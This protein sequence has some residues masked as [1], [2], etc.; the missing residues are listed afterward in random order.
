M[1]GRSLILLAVLLLPLAPAAAETVSVGGSPEG[2]SVELV[3]SGALRTVL[4]Y[5]IGSFER[6]TVEID[7][8][9]YD[10]VS[11][12]GESDIMTSGLPL[13]PDVARSIIIPD[14]AEM[15][16]RV[17]SADYID[18]AGVRVAP[19]KGILTRDI[20]PATVPYSFDGFYETD[21]WYPSELAYAREPYIMRDV[22]GQVVVVNPFQY[23]PSLETLRIYDR[24]EI[25]VVSV[26]PGKTNVLERRPPGGVDHEFRKIY[27]SHFLNFPSGEDRLRYTPIGEVGNMLV[28]CYDSFMASM[29]PFVEWK[30]QMGV[31]CEMVA[32]STVGSNATAIR[33]YIQDYYDTSGVTFVLL[34]GDATEIP[35]LSS[36][37]GA[38]DPSY[39]LVAGD[40]NYPD[41][42][43]G[44]FSATNTLDVDTQVL[45][46]VEYE[47]LPQSEESWYRKATG[48][49]SNQGPGDDG[50]DDDEHLE[51]IR[52]YL[53]EYTYTVVDQIYDPDANPAMVTTA[54]NDGRGLVNYTGHGSMTSWSSSDF[55]S[56]H[57]NALVNDNMLPFIISVACVNGRFDVGTCFAEA[58][59]RAT[60]DG[61]PTGALATYMSSIN[62]SWN[63]PMCAQDEVVRLLVNE[64]KR[65]FGGLCMNG[66]CQ[67]I[68]E[69]GAD[70]VSMFKTWH[71]FGDPS[72]RVRTNTPTSLT[73]THDASLD[74]LAG[75]FDVSVPGLEGAL[76]A[77]YYDGVLYGSAFTDSSGVAVIDIA[78]TPPSGIDVTVTVTAFNR[79][80]YV[81]TVLVAEP[82]VPVLSVTPSYFDVVL[83]PDQTSFETLTVEN[84]GEPQSVLHYELEIVDA[85]GPRDFTGSSVAASPSSY[86][87]GEAIDFSFSVYNGSSSGNWIRDV[88]FDFPTGATVVSCT[89]FSV[90]GRTLEW[91]ATTGDGASVGWLGDATNVV[92]PYETATATVRV[93]VSPGYTG[94][95]DIDFTLEGGGHGGSPHSESGTVTLEPTIAPGIT[96]IAPNGGEVWGI[97]ETHDITWDWSGAIDLVTIS[98]STDSGVGWVTL[99]S[100]TENDGVFPWL[101]DVPVSGNCLVKITSIS[102]ATAED[103]SDGFFSVYQP[104][105]WMSAAPTSGDVPAGESDGVTLTLDT[106]GLPEGDYYADIL[107][108]GNGGER[109]IVPIALHV[110][111]TGVPDVPEASVLYGNYPNPFDA[112]AETSIAFALP[113]RGSVHLA[114]YSPSGRLVRT[115]AD[116]VLDAGPHAIPWDGRDSSGAAVAAGVYMYRLET[117]DGALGGTM[118][119]TK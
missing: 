84:V 86:V 105:T 81:A 109:V 66:S 92:Y 40:D 94:D 119:L 82:Y 1:L 90:S 8:A 41:I 47:K 111:A 87:A 24:V 113:A 116:R 79:I 102:G 59:L 104:V 52:Y 34:V 68:D 80:P 14:D 62:Q 100:S 95:V 56:D 48:I 112:R 26:G 22:R 85:P 30:R 46:S 88:T 42:F 28:I 108:D 3:E 51:L 107:L 103:V 31:P 76:C 7:G 57:V 18:L 99:T 72:V 19:S 25:E 53:R 60:N 73:A 33:D 83:Q 97:G 64:E 89:D 9:T 39:S 23:N 13:L 4:E 36:S 55:T 106:T 37:S 75:T 32:V 5:R 38:S 69:Y 50:E 17:L 20:D 78:E 35:T 16:V 2:L 6:T 58:W 10:V 118:V 67:M 98:C 65:T 61:E 71:I 70:G 101:V 91:D 27:E 44:R 15:A 11:L 21:R 63:P 96:L 117:D 115:L 110:Q 114:V 29:E 54:L 74:P 43:V 12:P 45:R 49:A 77:L 93:S